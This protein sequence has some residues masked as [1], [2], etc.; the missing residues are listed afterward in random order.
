VTAEH[1]TRVSVGQGQ[2]PPNRLAI[3]FPHPFRSKEFDHLRS[4]S[5]TLK[6][7][8]PRHS[9]PEQNVPMLSKPKPRPDINSL[10][11]SIGERVR[12][13]C[14]V[15]LHRAPAKRKQGFKGHSLSASAGERVRERCRPASCHF[16]SH[17]QAGL[18]CHP[19][20]RAQIRIQ[21]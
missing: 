20:S 18:P 14:R 4:Q 7:K 3:L 5:V 6:R 16:Q 12:E 15:V 10:S 13:R 11:A 21:S 9:F 1:S 19:V 17:S 2:L 8:H